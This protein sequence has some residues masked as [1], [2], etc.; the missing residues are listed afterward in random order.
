MYCNL[1]KN[2]KRRTKNWG[3]VRARE[4]HWCNR[5]FR[6]LASCL[7]AFRNSFASNRRFRQRL[8]VLTF[9]I[10]NSTFLIPAAPAAQYRPLPVDGNSKL[11]PNSKFV[12]ANNIVSSDVLCIRVDMFRGG[13]DDMSQCKGF[14]WWEAEIK[15]LSPLGELLYHVSTVWRDRSYHEDLG[16]ED[17]KCRIFYY[18]SGPNASTGI[19]AKPKKELIRSATGNGVSITKFEGLTGSNGG[20]GGYYSKTI[21]ISTIEFFPNLDGK[22]NGVSIR[23]IFLN[24]EN[25]IVV[26]RKNSNEIERDYTNGSRIWRAP[27]VIYYRK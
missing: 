18:P 1:T 4:S 19:C 5:P 20:R 7:R 24:P 17:D 16:V 13:W 21:S 11:A 22:L 2:E 15:V 14:Y 8:R 26:S 10:L 23:E 27:I 25:T 12:A 3:R 6:W 9:F